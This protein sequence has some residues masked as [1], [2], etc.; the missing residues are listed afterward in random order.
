MAFNMLLWENREGHLIELPKHR[1]D[2]E[3]RLEDWIEQDSSLLG[4]DVLII[5][6]QV[7]TPF[8]GRIDLLAM[9]S[10][11]D[12]VIIELK[13]DRTPREVVAQVLDYASWVNNLSPREIYD[14]AEPYLSP[15]LKKGLSD[16]F[17]D[18]FDTELP[19]SFNADHRMV[20]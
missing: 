16:A 19:E 17:K 3:Q 12:I 8:S 9:D 1:L 5:G 7:S 10:H 11:G 6:R 20:I 2:E 14:L 15:R 13:R 18:R 4:L